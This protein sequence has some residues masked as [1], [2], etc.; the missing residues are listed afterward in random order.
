MA[1]YMPPTGYAPS[2][3]PP[4]PVAAGYPEQVQHPGPGPAPAPAPAPGFAVFP[5]PGGPGPAAG[6][7]APLLPLPGV[8]AG[9]EFL[10]PIDQVLVHQRAGRVENGSAVATG[11]HHRPRAADLAP[12]PPQVLHPRCRSPY[13]PASGGALLDLWLR[14]RHQL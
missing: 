1:G 6:P 7:A 3:P 5:S 4:Y 11:H 9:L 14:H 10:V 8:P 12:L 13:D 2:P